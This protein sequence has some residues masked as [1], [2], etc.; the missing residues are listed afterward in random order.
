VGLASAARGIRDI[1][2]HCTVVWNPQTGGVSG[3]A[4]DGYWVVTR[5]ADVKDVSRNTTLYSL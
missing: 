2:A 3:Y 1:A 4:D 5:H